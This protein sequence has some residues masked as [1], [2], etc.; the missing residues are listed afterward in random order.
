MGIC[1]YC[2]LQNYFKRH[3]FPL[4][5]SHVLIWEEKCVRACYLMAKCLISI[6][7]CSCLHRN[8][9]QKIQCTENNLAIC[10]LLAPNWLSTLPT[11]V[12]QCTLTLYICFR[13]TPS[14]LDHFPKLM[15]AIFL[16][17]NFY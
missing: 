17:H 1:I 7:L 12:L 10:F 8:V 13:I 9:L 16:S 5:R 3:L 11:A 6:I 15:S 2:Y 4:F 14:I